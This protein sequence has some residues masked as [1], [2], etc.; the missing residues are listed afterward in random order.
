MNDL[1]TRLCKIAIGYNIIAIFF[2]IISIL[3]CG[4]FLVKLVAVMNELARIIE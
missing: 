3:I 2:G 4:I 1:L